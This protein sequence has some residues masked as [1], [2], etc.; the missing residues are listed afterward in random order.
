MSK[1]VDQRRENLWG[2]SLI[3]SRIE[4]RENFTYNFK[5]FLGRKIQKDFYTKAK[6]QNN[7]NIESEISCI[8]P[9][10]RQYLLGSKSIQ[11]K[12]EIM[13]KKHIFQMI[14]FH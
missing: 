4:T 6:Y 5:T 2:G 12:T 8:S 1:K 14:D 10:K 13:K 9:Q 3:P 11:P 7:S